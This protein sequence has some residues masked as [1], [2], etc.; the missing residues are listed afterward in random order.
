MASPQETR[1]FFIAVFI[2][3]LGAFGFWIFGESSSL[4]APQTKE[5]K[6]EAKKS[7][8]KILCSIEGELSGYAKCGKGGE[9][10][11]VFADKKKTEKLFTIETQ[12][13]LDDCDNKECNDIEILDEQKTYTAEQT[14][15]NV[16]VFVPNYLTEKKLI[17]F[18]RKG[19]D[20]GSPK[21][22][23]EIRVHYLSGR[24]NSFIAEFDF[25]GIKADV[26]NF[27]RGKNK[28]IRLFAAEKKQTNDRDFFDEEKILF[29]SANDFEKKLSKF[30]NKIK[31]PETASLMSF[32]GLIHEI[33]K[34]PQN[35][36]KQVLIFALD[37]A[38][39]FPKARSYAF[40]PTGYSWFYA[41]QRDYNKDL[42]REN[43]F[44]R[45]RSE[46]QCEIKRPWKESFAQYYM[47]QIGTNLVPDFSVKY[48]KNKIKVLLLM[49]EISDKTYFQIEKER[50]IQELEKV[51]EERLIK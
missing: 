38:V 30:M 6:I 13:L 2:I 44:C 27:H 25:V 3:G 5:E 32:T 22:G 19:F 33:T 48:P 50:T 34:L 31:K 41:Y 11:H 46:T 45:T 23:D 21:P 42:E 28:V 40:N 17:E 24:G 36:K 18:I 37:D 35:D 4:N 12:K 26:I 47:R 10:V 14:P 49:P 8:Q 9:I 39:T 29:Y 51:V 16:S 15:K 20:T 7:S 1:D 43:E